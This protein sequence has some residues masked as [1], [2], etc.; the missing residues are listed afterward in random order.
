MT[1]TNPLNTPAE[2]HQYILDQFK[3]IPLFQDSTVTT[4]IVDK[5]RQNYTDLIAQLNVLD[6]DTMQLISLPLKD[7]EAEELRRL[8]SVMGNHSDPR[9]PTFLVDTS[10]MVALRVTGDGISSP[11]RISAA[12]D[13]ALYP[14]FIDLIV[15]YSII[16]QNAFYFDIIIPESGKEV[17]LEYVSDNGEI[18]KVGGE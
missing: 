9:G 18:R 4:R 6:P 5:L 12:E 3:G 11:F 1:T 16:K 7:N 15:N 8:N 14:I 17:K 2:R 13:P 10:N